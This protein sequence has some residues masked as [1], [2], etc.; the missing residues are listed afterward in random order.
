M[1]LQTGLI[2]KSFSLKFFIFF[3]PH[4]NEYLIILQKKNSNL[5]RNASKI[6]RFPINILHNHQLEPSFRQHSSIHLSSFKHSPIQIEKKTT[7]GVKAECTQGVE[8]IDD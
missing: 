6:K 8:E 5:K 2:N 7:R 4:I 3:I 1:T